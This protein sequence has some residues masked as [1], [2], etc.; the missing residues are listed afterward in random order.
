MGLAALLTHY[1]WRLACHVSTMYELHCKERYCGGC[2]FLLTTW[3]GIPRL[4][5]NALMVTFVVA[6]LAAVALINRD[7]LS[8]SEA[9]RFWTPLTICYTLLVI[10]MQGGFFLALHRRAAVLQE[11]VSSLPRNAG[12]RSLR[13]SLPPPWTAAPR[14]LLTATRFWLLG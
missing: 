6:N 10:Y 12:E 3:H 14:R 5:C 2:L 7:F 13:G 4:L 9:I 1:V 8:T 11:A